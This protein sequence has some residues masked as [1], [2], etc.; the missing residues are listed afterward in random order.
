MVTL[1]P[2]LPGALDLTGRL[3]DRGI[4]IGAGHS[5][6]DF[7]SSQ[8]GIAAGIAYGTHVFN[9][10]TRLDHRTPGLAAA[11]LGD[12]GATVGLI[13][14]GIHVHPQMIRIAWRLAGP[15]RLSLVS[16]A[17]AGL[18]MAPGKFHLGTQEVLVS[19]SSARLADG[20]L[21]GSVLPTNLGVRNLMTYTGCGIDIASRSVTS[22]PSR[23]LGLA[24]RGVIRTG[25]RADLVLLTQD[26]EVVTTFVAG[27]VAYA[28]EDAPWAALKSPK[29]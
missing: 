10:M 23:L 3:I 11:L 15:D 20:R 28:A 21:A 19:D 29:A 27:E 12:S 2:E 9:A 26:L 6:A 13:A 16:D 24:D 14:D 4:V 7:K 18:G 17:I 8:A 5:A 22:V 25:G 1:A